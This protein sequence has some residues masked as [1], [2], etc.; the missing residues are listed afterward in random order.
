VNIDDPHISAMDFSIHKGRIVT[1]GK[2]NGTTIHIKEIGFQKSGMQFTLQYQ[3]KDYR[4]FVPGLGE[5]NVYNAAAAIA[6]AIEIGMDI[7]GS[8]ER[9]ASF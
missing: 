5:H 9:L 8:L 4:A 2:S 1:Y 7:T 6:A 3:M